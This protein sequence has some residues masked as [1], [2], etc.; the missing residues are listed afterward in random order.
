M[1]GYPEHSL[2]ELLTKKHIIKIKIPIKMTDQKKKYTNDLIRKIRIAAAGYEA[3]K[4]CDYCPDSA[5]CVEVGEEL[6]TDFGSE[7]FLEAGIIYSGWS[8][9]QMVDELIRLAGLL[10]FLDA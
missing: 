6:I 5:G 4:N 7:E 1:Y 9:R 3:A 10:E 8:P 2:D